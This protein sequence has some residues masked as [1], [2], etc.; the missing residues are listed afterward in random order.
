M[1]NGYRDSRQRGRNGHCPWCGADGLGFWEKQTLGL[2]PR[3]CHHCAHYV[4]ASAPSAFLGIAI[5]LAP[6]LAAIA[7][8]DAAQLGAIASLLLSGMGLALGGCLAMAWQRRHLHL[9][10]HEGPAPKG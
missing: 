10:R 9:I 7:Y 8:G 4:R 2:F 6:F 1:E 5:V 3:Q